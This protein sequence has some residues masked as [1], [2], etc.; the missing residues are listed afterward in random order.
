MIK[1]PNLVLYIKNLPLKY[2]MSQLKSALAKEIQGG[3]FV[4]MSKRKRQRSRRTFA[5]LTLTRPEDMDTLLGSQ[6]ELT[7]RKLKFEI[8]KSHEE[9]KSETIGMLEKRVYIDNLPTKIKRN[10]VKNEFIKFGEIDRIFLKIVKDNRN[11]GTPPHSKCYITFSDK[12]SA[13]LCMQSSPYKF[14][15]HEIVVYQKQDTHQNRQAAFPKPSSPKI[16][17]PYYLNEKMG[18][19]ESY[20]RF[21]KKNSSGCYSGKNPR[22]SIEENLGEKKKINRYL[23]R[24]IFYYFESSKFISLETT[25]YRGLKYGSN[26]WMGQKIS[27]CFSMRNLVPKISEKNC[28]FDLDSFS[29]CNFYNHQSSNLKFQK[30]VSR[31]NDL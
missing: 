8:Y 27:Y 3:F 31:S 26:D 25:P 9:L 21:T 10:Q 13:D 5:I 4:K 14:L 7:G 22:F 15:N 24:N 6:I 2:D 19:Y 20:Q 1:N 12:K 11:K 28:G 23:S 18:G 16:K 29:S 30:Q 17:N